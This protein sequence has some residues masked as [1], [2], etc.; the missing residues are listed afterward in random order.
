MAGF[1]AT[2]RVQFDELKEKNQEQ[3]FE[4]NFPVIAR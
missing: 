2:S 1:C 4:R 3:I